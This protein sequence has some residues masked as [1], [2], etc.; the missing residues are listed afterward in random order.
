MCGD[1]FSWWKDRT[2]SWAYRRTTS[3]TWLPSAKTAWTVLLTSHDSAECSWSP[4]HVVH[5]ST[6]PCDSHAPAVIV[7]LCD[8]RSTTTQNNVQFCFSWTV[9]SGYVMLVTPASMIL[10][11][12][13]CEG[14]TVGWTDWMPVLVARLLWCGTVSLEISM[15]G[16]FGMLSWDCC[17]E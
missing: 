2:V 16:M 3:L 15:A 13:K 14:V 12:F 8:F 1:G 4:R 9:C 17:K 5:H 10:C 6:L 7:T 11:D